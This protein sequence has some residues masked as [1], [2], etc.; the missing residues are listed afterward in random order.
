VPGAR[1]AIKTKSGSAYFIIIPY[2]FIHGRG[3]AQVPNFCPPKQG[4]IPVFS[5]VGNLGN[6]S[7]DILVGFDA[8]VNPRPTRMSALRKKVGCARQNRQLHFRVLR[9]M[10]KTKNRLPFSA[11]HDK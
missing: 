3:L 4:R 8:F 2:E 5:N 11:G 9:I 1:T 10:K 6:R 7:A